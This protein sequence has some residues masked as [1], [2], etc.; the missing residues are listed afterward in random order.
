ML[1]C[2]TLNIP[3]RKTYDSLGFCDFLEFENQDMRADHLSSNL[4]RDIFLIQI[5]KIKILGVNLKSDL[6]FLV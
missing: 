3:L 4:K 1:L 5:S 6:R 2:I